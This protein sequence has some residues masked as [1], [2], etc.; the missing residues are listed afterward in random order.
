MHIYFAQPHKIAKPFKIDPRQTKGTLLVF[1]V[2]LGENENKRIEK[3][4]LIANPDLL[5]YYGSAGCLYYA[6]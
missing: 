5:F 1:N 3:K 4:I 2:A 6:Y